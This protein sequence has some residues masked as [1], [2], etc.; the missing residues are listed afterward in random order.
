M[1]GKDLAA[2]RHT[3][4]YA[5]IQKHRA[6]TWSYGHFVGAYGVYGVS[7][8]KDARRESFPADASASAAFSTLFEGKESKKIAERLHLESTSIAVR[9]HSD[10]KRIA[11]EG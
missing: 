3:F 11:H 8:V 9:E 6:L 7:G 4:V 10:S 5:R 2:K 1:H